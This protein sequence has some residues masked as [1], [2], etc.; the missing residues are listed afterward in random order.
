MSSILNAVSRAKME[1]EVWDNSNDY[2]F[3]MRANDCARE[4]NCQETL[5][6]K[7]CPITLDN[8]GRWFLPKEF[9]QIICIGGQNVLNNGTIRQ[10]PIIY[11]EQPFLQ[12]CNINGLNNSFNNL[13]VQR[14]SNYLQFYGQYDTFQ[15]LCISYLAYNVDEHGTMQVPD[16][17]E[18]PIMYYLCMMWSLRHMKDYNQFQYQQWQQFYYTYRRKIVSESNQIRFKEMRPQILEAMNTIL[19][20]IGYGNR[21]Y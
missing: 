15:N 14:N 1:L 3:E 10:V 13:T 11:W 8:N 21:F 12:T 6:K 18:E 16:E 2:W 5:I 4:F 7:N 20:G 17:F 9:K 19:N